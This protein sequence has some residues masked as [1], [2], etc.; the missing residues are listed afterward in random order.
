MRT[1]PEVL[2]FLGRQP[3]S[4][5]TEIEVKSEFIRAWTTKGQEPYMIR[6]ADLRSQG[7]WLDCGQEGLPDFNLLAL[8]EAEKEVEFY[9][10]LMFTKT[11][12]VWDDEADWKYQLDFVYQPVDECDLYCTINVP[13]EFPIY[14]ET[15]D[16]ELRRI[17]IQDIAKER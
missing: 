15:G 3:E 2:A 9:G 17:E 11:W 7:E 6:T 4:R 16:G 1:A 14:Q 10:D 13:A 5:S 12:D 8:L